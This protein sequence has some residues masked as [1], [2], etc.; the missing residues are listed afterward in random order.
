MTQ[1][2]IAYANWLE[3]K[4]HN[5]AYEQETGR[6]NKATETQAQ[7]E[8]KETQRHN[9]RSEKSVAYSNATNRK[10]VN[11]TR[12]HNKKSEKLAAKEVATKVKTVKENIRHNKATEKETKRHNFVTEGTEKSK[13]AESI[14]SN[15]SNE[16]IKRMSN[17]IDQAFKQGSLEQT[18][19][20]NQMENAWNT[21]RNNEQY[22]HNAKTEFE[23]RMD[24]L[25][26]QQ[27]WGQQ[28]WNEL[29]RYLLDQKRMNAEMDDKDAGLLNDFIRT[30]APFIPGYKK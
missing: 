30:V 15:L 16:S 5:Q 17:A 4:R 6:H 19:L 28:N 29:R 12:R 23:T 9:K 26:A 18:A 13:V 10:A 14:R 24:R 1:N 7:K 11:E 25:F 20:R 21:V 22:R 3:T 27:K 8:L 2:T